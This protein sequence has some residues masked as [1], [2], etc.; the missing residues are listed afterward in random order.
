MLAVLQEFVGLLVGAI[1]Q[2]GTG[3]ATGIANFAKS[4]FLE[5]SDQGVVTGL[6]V[7]GGIIGIF[8]GIALAV[9]ITTKVYMWIMSLGHNY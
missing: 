2:L 1:V 8:G 9:G 5:V 6:S 4:L 3:L 7:V